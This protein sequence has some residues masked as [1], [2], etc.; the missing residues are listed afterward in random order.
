VLDVEEALRFLAVSAGIIH[1]DNYI[2]I[3]HNTYLYEVNGKFSLIPWD[4]N[5]V[6]G[7]FNSGIR[8]NGIINFY[9]DE[10]TSGPVNRF[11]LVDRLLSY[12]PY[13]KKYHGYLQELLDGPFSPDVILPRIDQLVEMTR[14]YAKADTEMF[15]SYEDWER[16]IN[17]DLR[18]P[19]IF[20]GWQAGG[21]TPMMPW[22]IHRW[23]TANLRKNFGVGSLFE[24]MPIFKETDID[25]LRKTVSQETA[26]LFLQNLYGPLMYPQPPRQSGFGPNSL[27]LKTFIVARWES[28]QQQLNGERQSSS[29][30]GNGNGAS[31]WMVDMFTPPPEF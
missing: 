30:F 14:P 12:Q 22:F 26:D 5:M 8:K 13:L 10:P 21:P 6:F 15:Y 23:E 19:D 3:G 29:G 27:G 24:L 17:E 1:L 20:E 28:V 25:K 9:I 2:G 16:C 7:T 18:P 31:M 11:P 4:L